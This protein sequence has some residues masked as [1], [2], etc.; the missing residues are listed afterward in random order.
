MAHQ[1]YKVANTH[2]H[3]ISEWTIL[4]R[5]IH[6]DTPHL[7]GMNGDVQYYLSNLAFK[8]AEQLEY[9]KRRIIILQQEVNLSGETVSPKR[10][11]LQYMK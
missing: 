3:E 1:A 5:L 10:L 11:I 2:A 4:S 9:S 8:N 7:G 6:A